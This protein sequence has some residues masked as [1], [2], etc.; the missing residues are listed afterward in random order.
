M[1]KVK[2]RCRVFAVG[3]MLKC[4]DERVFSL[5]FNVWSLKFAPSG[6]KGL[7]F[8]NHRDFIKIRLFGNCRVIRVL[9][10]FA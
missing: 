9:K 5:R 2:T 10:G 1:F 8:G 4:F 6:V 7:R 3:E